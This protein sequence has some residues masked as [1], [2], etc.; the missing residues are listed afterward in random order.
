MMSY[1]KHLFLARLTSL[2]AIYSLHQLMG[3]S[4]FACESLQQCSSNGD[5]IVQHLQMFVS[6]APASRKSTPRRSCTR[7]VPTNFA[8]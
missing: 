1:A 7:E 8:Q 6:R 4:S 3:L 2:L 5:T